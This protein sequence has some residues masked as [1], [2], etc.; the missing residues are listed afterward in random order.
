MTSH[1]IVTVMTVSNHG[2][3]QFNFE[4]QAPDQAKATA[5]A[6]IKAEELSFHDYE[7]GITEHAEVV[8]VQPKGL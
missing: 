8:D 5:E 4:L 3:G 6:V 2:R 7:Y 1:W